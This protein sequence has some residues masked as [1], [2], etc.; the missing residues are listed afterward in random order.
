[1]GLGLDSDGPHGPN[2]HFSLDSFIRGAKA[3][4]HF[5]QEI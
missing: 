5:L 1:M 3:S 4:A 2:E